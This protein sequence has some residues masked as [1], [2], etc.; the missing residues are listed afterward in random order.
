MTTERDKKGGVPEWGDT[1][2]FHSFETL[3]DGWD[4][5]TDCDEDK[6][7]GRVILYGIFPQ[8]PDVARMCWCMPALVW[9]AP[10][11]DLFELPAVVANGQPAETV[12]HVNHAVR[13]YVP[14]ER[15]KRYVRTLTL[16]DTFL[17]KTD[18]LTD[19]ITFKRRANESAQSA[20]LRWQTDR[21]A[22]VA[23]GLVITDHECVASLMMGFPLSKAQRTTLE[24]MW[25]PDLD[26]WRDL[27]GALQRL[28][29]RRTLGASNNP[30][31]A[32]A[33][34]DRDGDVIMQH[35][36]AFTGGRR[37]Q[38]NWGGSNNWNNNR[39]KGGWNNNRNKGGWNDN[40][41]KGGWTDNRNKGAWPNNSPNNKGKGKRGGKP[42]GKGKKGFG[43]P[44]GKAAYFVEYAEPAWD[45]DSQWGAQEWHGYDDWNTASNDWSGEGSSSSQL[46][47]SSSNDWHGGSSSSSHAQP[48][49]LD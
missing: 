34:H 10:R 17:H 30:S 35:Y 21:T 43:K 25:N 33:T 6:K 40:R 9:Q 26:G 2:L 45:D 15:L 5:G 1:Q 49:R 20:L 7:V 46:Q 48:F 44:K 13:N 23:D 36:A 24:G 19:F 37:G 22:L 31:R 41:N 47:P 14:L 3:I 28:L 27:Y 38:N 32:T 4:L 39:N 8:H 12:Q 42:K 11:D 16:Q 18:R 29:S